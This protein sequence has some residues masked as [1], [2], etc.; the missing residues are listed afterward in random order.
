[1]SPDPRGARALPPARAIPAYFSVVA[2]GNG[3]DTAHDSRENERLAALGRV[4]AGVA[5]D[6]NNILTVVTLCA[7]ILDSQ[8]EFDDRGREQL[9]LIQRETERGASM[10]WQ[11]LDF[12]QRDPIVL[13]PVDLDA[14]FAELL[15]V[16]RRTHRPEVAVTFRT[17]GAPH[18]VMGDGARLEQS[19]INLATNSMDAIPDAGAIDIALDRVGRR[20]GRAA[21][22]WIRITLSDT[23]AGI[24]PEV[25]PRI[26]EPFFSTKPHGHGTGLGLAQ[27]Q[28]LVAQHHGDIDVTSVPVQ[29]TTVEI[30]IPAI[31][32]PRPLGGP[33]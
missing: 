17:D 16:F 30:W 28:S 12:A 13:A 14:F 18:W 15:P 31:A 4:A 7:N 8:Y 3:P 19:M 10:V 2:R 20:E 21:G 23:G 6:F 25:L 33:T 9:A 22:P 1:M 5:H 11:I 24:P 32:R 29:G 27:V 26:F